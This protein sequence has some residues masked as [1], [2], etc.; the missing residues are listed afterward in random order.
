MYI[1]FVDFTLLLDITWDGN[2]GSV[3]FC[4]SFSEI[5]GFISFWSPVRKPDEKQLFVCALKN[6]PGRKKP[7]VLG[8]RLRVRQ[9]QIERAPYICWHSE[10]Q[11]VSYSCR[12]ATIKLSSYPDCLTITVNDQLTSL[13]RTQLHL[14]VRFNY[15]N[16]F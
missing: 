13:F 8:K 15:L 6:I 12:N 2:Q 14:M 3:S 11:V 16:L 4:S 7:A 9:L 10:T 5:T 1:F